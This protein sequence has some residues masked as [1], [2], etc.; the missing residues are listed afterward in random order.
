MPVGR[1]T[2]AGAA[3]P[4]SG[5]VSAA[6][7]PLMRLAARLLTE[8]RFDTDPDGAWQELH[9]ASRAARVN[10]RDTLRGTTGA[11]AAAYLAGA[12]ALLDDLENADAAATAAQVGGPFDPLRAF[13]AGNGVT[14]N[15]AAAGLPEMNAAVRDT[16][17]QLTLDLDNAFTAATARLEQAVRDTVAVTGPGAERAR[18]TVWNQF[19]SKGLT[20][21]G[22]KG[23][24]LRLE[25]WEDTLCETFLSRTA[26]DAYTSH[27]RQ[28]GLA[29]VAVSW[30]VN[31]CVICGPWEGELLALDSAAMAAFTAAH[32]YPVPKGTL[33]A[34]ITAGLFHPHCRHTVAAWIPGV[35]S[36]PERGR[37]ASDESASAARERAMEQH[38]A[39]WERKS[40]LALTR[41]DRLSAS[42][43]AGEWRAKLTEHRALA[44]GF[45]AV[46]DAQPERDLQAGLAAIFQAP[47]RPSADLG[48]DAG[49]DFDGLDQDAAA[50]PSLGVPP[51]AV[52]AGDDPVDD[53]RTRR[54]LRQAA[55]DA[56]DAFTQSPELNP[57][58]YLLRMVNVVALGE[59][60][61]ARF[62]L[63][64]EDD[65]QFGTLTVFVA[66]GESGPEVVLSA[67]D[68]VSEHASIRD[69]VREIGDAF[70]DA[71]NQTEDT[72]TGAAPPS[73][74]VD[75]AGVLFEG[76]TRDAR[77]MA[78]ARG[79]AEQAAESYT[80]AFG[81]YVEFDDLTVVGTVTYTDFLVFADAGDEDPTGR[82]RIGVDGTS[83]AA[84]RVDVMWARAADPGDDAH[85]NEVAAQFTQAWKQDVSPVAL[86]GDGFAVL[87]RDMFTSAN[88]GAVRDAIFDVFENHDYG[89]FT[90]E[91]ASAVRSDNRWKIK[92][93]LVAGGKPVGSFERSLDTDGTEYTVHHDFLQIDDEFH[94]RGFASAFNAHLM[95]WYRAS[96]VTWIRIYAGLEAGGYAWARAGFDWSTKFEAEKMWRS[97]TQTANAYRSMARNRRLQ[98]SAQ[99]IDATIAAA[100]LAGADV[101]EAQADAAFALLERADNATW[102]TRD[103]PTPFDVS[104]IGRPPNATRQHEWLG[105]EVLIA[106]PWHGKRRI[107]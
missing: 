33:P 60:T 27:A 39:E 102:D 87:A 85:M 67:A 30:S 3:A 14:F 62:D 61:M 55:S 93:D 94:G 36:L 21:P 50:A 59:R 98:A 99:G 37:K 74:G 46:A 2:V 31:E 58:D 65:D 54:R 77:A 86:G 48:D 32:A 103:Y 1:S 9:A 101:F 66:D 43:R 23:R 51:G 68:A 13:V 53:V 25:A 78:Y 106:N 10:L 45:L 63:L 22:S 15:E 29:C 79:T 95:N 100:L 6:C 40:D 11:A 42:R 20:V 8:G 41:L 90:V 18:S 57:D 80:D 88:V 4:L 7:T 73:L 56:A 19:L 44:S 70:V 82:F 83:N 72:S 49:D 35:T 105:K 107:V 5:A 75:P 69:Q 38:I 97:L 34:A 12:D 17:A 71:W 92:G 16:A 76:T 81:D 84:D 47:Q 104:E 52:L 26:T 91:V 96:G 89:D 24:N 28:A 64:D